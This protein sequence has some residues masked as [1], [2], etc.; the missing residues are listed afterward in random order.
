MDTSRFVS[1]FWYE[2]GGFESSFTPAQLQQIRHVTLSHV[3]CLTMDEI[4][5]IQP[6]VFLSPDDFRNVRLPCDSPL[7]DNLDLSAWAERDFDDI[8]NK[9]N[10]KRETRESARRSKRSKTATTT[11]RPKTKTKTKKTKRKRPE[12]TT[13]KIKVANVTTSSVK[14]E[15]KYGGS[16]GVTANSIPPKPAYKPQGQYT[17][18]D[19][20]D[21]TYLF[22]V[23]PTHTTPKPMEINIKIQYFLP[24]TTE[25]STT[26]RPT[27][28]RKK[29]STRKPNNS[30]D[31]TV[32]ITQRPPAKK[33]D[34]YDSLRPK[35]V[36]FNNKQPSYTVT[37]TKRP[38]HI[39]DKPSFEESYRPHNDQTTKKPYI[40]R[41]QTH[42]QNSYGQ[43]VYEDLPFS[44]SNRPY[45]DSYTTRPNYRPQNSYYDYDKRPPQNNYDPI[46]DVYSQVYNAHD[47]IGDVPKKPTFGHTDYNNDKIRQPIHIYST[48]HV[49]RVDINDKLDFKS[50]LITKRKDEDYDDRDFVKISSVKAGVLLTDK[51]EFLQERGGEM[52]LGEN[53]RKI[54]VVD[55]DISPSEVE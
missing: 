15:N 3:L 28:K 36:Y 19:N 18:N 47:R 39:Y 8:S 5:T 52:D 24:Q 31:N 29:T 22:G 7:I 34:S 55:I 6:F 32:L 42:Y 16:N 38:V 13:V 53:Q 4:R 50:R 46:N 49:D 21:V 30:Y 2:N 33:P 35:P 9:I 45:Y 41:P 17:N 44:T 54:R 12:N 37:D 51:G 10:F 11:T 40:I 26:A 27:R 20:T 14:V 25:T 23:V 48:S 1:R 43:T